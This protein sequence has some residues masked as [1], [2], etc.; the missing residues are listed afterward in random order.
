VDMKVSPT[1]HQHSDQFDVW[2]EVGSW[3]IEHDDCGGGRVAATPQVEK[4]WWSEAA[5]RGTAQWLLSCQ[6]CGAVTLILQ[7]EESMAALR[8]LAVGG[9]SLETGVEFRRGHSPG[10]RWLMHTDIVEQ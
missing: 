2:R 4:R 5:K 10:D 9:S 6:A 3:G 7:T 8:R 1:S